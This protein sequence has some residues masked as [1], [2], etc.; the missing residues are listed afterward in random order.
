MDL[1]GDRD[2]TGKPTPGWGEPV[3]RAPSPQKG[4]GG[5]S[6]EKLRNNINPNEITVIEANKR[7]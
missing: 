3:R 1:G 6:D 7:E 2:N 5:S 4:R